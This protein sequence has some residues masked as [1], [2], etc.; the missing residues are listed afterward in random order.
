MIRIINGVAYESKTLDTINIQALDLGNGHLEVCGQRAR[1]WEELD[2]SP[3]AVGHYLE[4]LERH[5]EETREEREALSLKMA[6]KRA[7]TRVRRLC[8]VM[9][10]DTMLTGTYK[11]N[12]LDLALCKRH[13]KE[14]IRRVTRTIPSFRAVVAFEQQDRG[15]W[16]FHLACEKVPAALRSSG[17]KIKSYEFLRRIWRSV[18]GDL[19]GNID[20]SQGENKKR[21]PARIASYLSKYLMKAFAEGDKW[22]N[23][24]TRYGAIEVPQPLK[25]GQFASMR[26]AVEACYHLIDDQAQVVDRFLSRWQ[27]VFF[28]VV[29]NQRITSPP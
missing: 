19:G 6:A 7:A 2:W 4:A 21:S 15:A 18:V 23:R 1:S 29:E 27:D 26:H 10:A 16:H 24:W 11:A 17:V 14:F 22:S 9:G 28:L 13:V 25:L 3:L 20:V 12:Q 8:K 5:R